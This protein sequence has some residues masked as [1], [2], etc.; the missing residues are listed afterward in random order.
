MSKLV[1]QE[2]GSRS[3]KEAAL[4]KALREEEFLMNLDGLSLPLEP[5]VHVKTLI[6]DSTTLFQ[7][8]LMPMKLFFNTM[9]DEKYVTIFKRG[10]DLRYIS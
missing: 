2:S 8:N 4:R 1:S 9:E 5:S 3:Q 10:D 6:P 7:S